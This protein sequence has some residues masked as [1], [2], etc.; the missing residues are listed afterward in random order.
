MMNRLSTSATETVRVLVATLDERIDPAA[1]GDTFTLHSRD[2]QDIATL[3]ATLQEHPIDVILTDSVAIC[4]FMQRWPQQIPVLFI[5][6]PED[7]ETT[8]NDATDVIL[9]PLNTPI[10][11]NRLR[12]LSRLHPAET[13]RMLFEALR[14]PIFLVSRRD[15]AFDLL[16]L[17]RAD[18][19][20]VAAMFPQD[21][22][23]ARETGSLLKV[24]DQALAEQSVQSVEYEWWEAA[25][26][27]KHWY[28]ATIT[29]L[30]DE[31]VA[32]LVQEVTERKQAEEALRESER[33][34]RHLFDSANDGIFL[35]DVQ[36]GNITEC[37][38]QAARML[39][40]TT[41]EL[42]GTPIDEIEIPPEVGN[43]S[44]GDL[45]NTNLLIIEGR[46]RRRDGS[47]IPVETSTR[48]I[49]FHDRPALL[50][51]VRD[52][53]ERKR[54]LHAEKEQRQ[55][56]EALRD[57]AA[58][59]NTAINSA[60]VLDSIMQNIPRVI[61]NA[62]VNIMLIDADTNEA[63]I[64]RHSGYERYGASD[65]E[66]MNTR[67]HVQ[68]SEVMSAILEH[69]QP[70]VVQDV[71]RG[72]TRWAVSPI[73]TA[74]HSLIASP[75]IAND[76]VVGFINIDSREVGAFSVELGRRLFAF[77][78]QAAIAIQNARLFEQTRQHADEL[79]R[80][81]QDRTAELETANAAL[82]DQIEQRHAVERQLEAERTLLRTLID[83][84]PDAI[85]IKDE[86]LRFVEA[87]LGTQRELNAPTLKEIIGRTDADYLP[88]ER[89]ER[90][91]A[92]DRRV[93]ESGRAISNATEMYTDS[94]GETHHLVCSKIPMQNANGDVT[95]I[96]G[97]HHDITDL[98]NAREQ[99]ER[100]LTSARCLLWHA[101]VTPTPD[102]D[103]AWHLEVTNEHAA[104][105]FLPMPDHA[106]GYTAAWRASIPS[107]DV[108]RGQYVF[109][110]HV[111][112]ER[113]D[114]SHEYR[115]RTVDGVLH[116]LAEEVRVHPLDDGRYNLVGVCTEITD[117]KVA[118]IQLQRMNEQLEERVEERTQR[119]SKANRELRLEIGERK[120]AEE[121]ERNQRILAE[122]LQE[123]A[124][125]INSTLDQDHV[126]NTLFNAL[127]SVVPHDSANIMF[128]EEPNSARVIQA[129]GYNPDITG[130]VFDFSNWGNFLDAVRYAQPVIIRD[131]HNDTRWQ[132]IGPVEHIRSH[133]VVPIRTGEQMIGFLNLDSAQVDHFTAEQAHWLIAF[134]NQAGTAIRNAR[135]MSEIRAYADDLEQRVQ[136]RTQEVKVERARLKAILDAMRD[137]VIFQDTKGHVQFTNRALTTLTGYEAEAWIHGNLREMIFDNPHSTHA[138]RAER[139]VDSQGY[140]EGEQL[141]RRRDDSTFDAVLVSTEVRNDDGD[142]TGIVTVIRDI[143][144][145]KAL[146]EQKARFIAMASHELRTP[147]ANIKMR[148]FLMRRDPARFAE[149]IKIA[150]S[151]TNLMKQLVEDMFDLSRF[152]RGVI[153][154][155]REEHSLQAIIEETLSYFEPEAE[156]QQIDFGA[157]LPDTPLSLYVDRFRLMQV[158]TNLIKNALNYTPEQGKIR[159]T[160]QQTEDAVLVY[161]SDTGPGISAEVRAQL[162][163]P[164]FRGTNDNLGAGLGLS[165]SHEIISGHGG[166][167]TVESTVGEGSTFIVRLPL[168]PLSHPPQEDA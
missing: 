60:D 38:P 82:R 78:S 120:A 16:T 103:Y 164:F 10:L 96:I 53:S 41:D 11:R 94:Q 33:R 122:S 152:E 57:S 85:Y 107:E 143:S 133:I 142:P 151:V 22:A 39:G 54:A 166:E 162:F 1:L 55:L 167:L 160:M 117:R 50:C 130:W 63:Y 26:K 111:R 20:N 95:H 91:A 70:I 116:W 48:I 42:I 136:V 36:S 43:D 168:I 73:S 127:Q 2:P 129:R 147:L 149:H 92:M 65:Q 154:L 69:H 84:I 90:L 89:A 15:N 30:S 145:A 14:E 44:S 115:C 93:F 101:T 59:F 5:T 138:K 132:S 19:V 110:T 102:G 83:T 45:S 148:L 161:V 153:E 158:F 119:L 37:N 157:E 121:R 87:N 97:V 100:V 114:Y 28:E 128:V 56:A 113:Y 68:D 25:T 24:L 124:A 40:Y 163:Q 12:W 106:A 75:I 108:A 7:A 64:V 8:L 17:T 77:C 23:T 6:N 134:A 18:Q 144:Q 112:W 21:K 66:M 35:I 74:I 32:V 47:S 137:G 123:S 81:V 29:P 34:Y 80:R 4:H 99:L 118:E 72:I 141:I 51:F 150:E 104:Q 13:Y 61:P 27:T 86:Q 67:I 140:W 62:S 131:T 146:E 79:E 49:T 71:Q 159:V 9:R 109:N 156:R 76:Q 58:A 88:A 46:Y 125:A 126:F 135:M 52:I 165:I 139:A 31:R 3:A 105:T 155:E 98:Q